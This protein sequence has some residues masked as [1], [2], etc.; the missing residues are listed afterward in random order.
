[1]AFNYRN[2][3]IKKVILILLKNLTNVTKIN[4][5]F[6]NKK[7]ISFLKYYVS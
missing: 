5:T 3:I 4:I 7:I 2:Y 1:M 6:L